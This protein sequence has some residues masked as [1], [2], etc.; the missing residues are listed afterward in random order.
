MTENIT[1]Q[2]AINIIKGSLKYYVTY[3][4]GLRSNPYVR[5]DVDILQIKKNCEAIKEGFENY[6]YDLRVLK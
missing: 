4:E 1:K 5:K 3:L 6:T 2:Q